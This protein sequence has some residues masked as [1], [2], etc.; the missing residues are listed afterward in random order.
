MAEDFSRSRQYEYKAN[1]NL[2]LEAD[3]DGL[4]RA[5]DEASGEVETIHGK[6]D[7]LRMGDRL[8]YEKGQTS[9]QAE[10]KPNI[11]RSH[12][13]EAITGISKKKKQ[14]NK[15]ILIGT[16]DLDSIN[17]R[18]K[19]RETRVAYEE[20]LSLIQVH[21]LCNLQLYAI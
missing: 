17:Y 8:T 12:E 20:L 6:T 10:Q 11:K 18:P 15:N 4:R 13:D 9:I 1:S 16:E 21:N 5:R 7:K 2:V 3:R 14:G 19:T